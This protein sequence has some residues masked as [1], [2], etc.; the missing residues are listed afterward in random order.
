MRKWL[1][2]SR[3]SRLLHLISVVPK[4]EDRKECYNF[5]LNQL[6]ILKALKSAIIQWFLFWKLLLVFIL[7]Y[8]F[9]TQVISSFCN[10]CL[11]FLSD[12][13]WETLAIQLI[14]VIIYTFGVRKMTKFDLIRGLKFLPKKFF[15]INGKGK[16]WNIL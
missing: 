11:L 2:K 4:E 3:R 15:K 8:S 13:S 14:T 6:K 10:F 12:Q 5:L 9:Y 1:K 7:D 16:M